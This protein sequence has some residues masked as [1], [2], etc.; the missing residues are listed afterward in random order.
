[1]YKC[2]TLS[3]LGVELMAY[4]V[5]ICSD[6]MDTDSFS[7]LILAEYTLAN[8]GQILVSLVDLCWPLT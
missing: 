5:Y 3:I 6:F 1:M 7:K 8:S 2:L 4:M